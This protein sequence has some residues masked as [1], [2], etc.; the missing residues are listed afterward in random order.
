MT[1]NEI[2]EALNCC[3]DTIIIRYYDRPGKTVDIHI[4][5]I[6][7]VLNRQQAEIERLT[8]ARQ[9]TFIKINR[10]DLSEDVRNAM[11]SGRIILAQDSKPE[12]EV[13]PTAET[14]VNDFKTA[15]LK[16][17]FPYDVANKKQYSINAYAVEKA[18]EEVAEQ[19]P[20]VPAA[21]VKANLLEV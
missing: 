19:I 16:K 7:G 9:P 2:I 13:I 8:E 10:V 15:L 21:L 5:E 11:K 12:I 1:D 18:I 6:A 20:P 14:I 17:I 3:Q 4:R